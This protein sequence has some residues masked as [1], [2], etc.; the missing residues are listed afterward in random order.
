M[1]YIIQSPAGSVN[2]KGT[3]RGKAETD[4][5]GVKVGQGLPP[6]YQWNVWVLDLAFEEAMGVLTDDQ[7]E[8]MAGLFQLLAMHTDPTHSDT[9]SLDDIENFHELR[10]WGGILAN[11]NI[12]GFYGVDKKNRAIVELGLIAKKNNGP[13]PLPDRVRMRNRWRR[14]LRGDFGGSPQ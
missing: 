2:D 1:W 12:R 13:T 5:S 10:D 7:Y 11:L 8:H 14:Y 4:Q 9:L 6:G 3:G